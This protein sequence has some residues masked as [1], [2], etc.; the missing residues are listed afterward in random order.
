MSK[1]NIF[2]TI[3]KELSSIVK[4]K[5][6]LMI[7][8][9]TPL[10]I[11]MYVILMGL[12]YDTMFEETTDTYNVGI[13]YELNENEKNLVQDL[14]LEFEKYN[15]K[16]EMQEAFENG[17]I[18]AFV[19]LENNNY[20]ISMNPMNEDSSYAGMELE[21][22]L[23]SYNNLL[24]QNYLL[25]NNINPNQVFNMINIGYEELG[26][27]N[28]MLD[29]LITLSFVFVVMFV[30]LTAISC[31]TAS[32]AGEKENGTLETLLTFPIKSNELII[33]KYLAIF[34]SCVMTAIIG[35][36]LSIVSLNIAAN[37]FETFKGVALNFGFETIALSMVILISFSLIISGLSIAIASFSKS[38][39]EAQSALQPLSFVVL[40]PEFMTMFGISTSS[41]LSIIPV[42][43]HS[44][45]LNDI[46]CNNINYTHIILMLV[47]SIVYIVI[48]IAYISKQ[49]KS[50]KILFS[51]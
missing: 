34:I 47:S 27:D 8:L 28:S 33:G 3:K 35:I 11:P 48:L 30:T 2:I 23:S 22:Y 19:V 16:E 39:K 45:I 32:T 40:I 5:K 41:T 24:A 15:T 51:I 13:N 44:L 42:L 36:I 14:S 50:E 12:M 9:L 38:Y 7:L 1:K 17:D 26:G 20:I 10:L 37:T 31:A 49:Y 18:S 21:T 25:E 4:D 46:F 6:T 29:L 43:G